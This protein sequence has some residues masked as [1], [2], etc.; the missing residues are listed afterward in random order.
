[1]DDRWVLKYH[2]YKNQ[3]L[4][5]ELNQNWNNLLFLHNPT[6]NVCPMLRLNYLEVNPGVLIQLV[7]KNIPGRP[8]ICYKC[9]S[10]FI[11]PMHLFSCSSAI[12]L[13]QAFI[14]Q[15]LRELSSSWPPFV[16]SRFL[17]VLN[18]PIKESV[19]KE[20]SKVIKRGVFECLQWKLK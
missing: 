13:S 2:Q 9:N 18:N 1:M 12:E 15:S 17:N 14:P 16:I 6:R 7:S 19:T 10:A 11:N 5:E 3:L 8:S 20:L 4:S